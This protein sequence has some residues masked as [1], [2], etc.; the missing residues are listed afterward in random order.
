MKPLV[1]YHP[2]QN[3]AHISAC[4][5]EVIE[6]QGVGL[7]MNTTYDTKLRGEAWFDIEK[8][9]KVDERVLSA[10]EN[11]DLM[12]VSTGLWSDNEESEGTFGVN[13]EPYTAIARNF[14]PDHLA[15]LPD[16][17]GAFSVEQGGGLFQV[18]ALSHS[19]TRGRLM[20]LI[21]ERHGEDAWVVD[22]FEGFF[23]FADGRRLF[24]LNYTSTDDVISITEAPPEAVVSQ[25]LYRTIDGTMIGNS[26]VKPNFSKPE[27]KTVKVKPEVKKI[28]DGLI[29]NEDLSWSETQREFLEKQEVKFLEGLTVNAAPAEP[30]KVEPEPTKVEP[31]KND[32]KPV[33][34]DDPTVNSVPAKTV[35]EY[36]STAPVGMQDVLRRGVAAHEK[37][38]SDLV[39]VITAN[40]ENQF[41]EKE[42]RAMPHE[43]LSKMAM[44][45][46]QK[47]PAPAPGDDDDEDT[48]FLPPMYQGQ[49]QGNAQLAANSAQGSDELPMVMQPMILDP[50]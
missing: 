44:L 17:I 8:T 41:E 33:N 27:S 12:E 30:T 39:S 11:G 10:L 18:N 5:P 31:S 21:N 2:K 16:Q 3:G 6:S 32:T 24:R 7:I 37:E 40:E 1:V 14:R 15:I 29:A 38:I 49:G 43:T 34:P 45:A 22:V 19:D 47:Q 26:T 4:T 46:N 42:L 28:V 13:N 50:K 36:I 9:R 35:D 23:V 20:Q 25:T 48:S